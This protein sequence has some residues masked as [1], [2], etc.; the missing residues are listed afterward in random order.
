M[1][2]KVIPITFTK[3]STPPALSHSMSRKMR[4]KSV[5]Q[6]N[7]NGKNSLLISHWNLGSKKWTNKRNQIQALVDT[8]NPDIIFISEANL[9]DLTPPH[10]SLISGYSITLPKTVVRN[11]T[12]RLVLLTKDN[13]EFELMENLM[14]D[15]VSSIWIKISRQG[16][17]G[18]LVCGI[19]REHQY[20]NQQSDWSLQPAE[21]SKRWAQFLRQVETA[22]IS[23]ICHLIGDFNLDYKKWNA[24]D[25]AHLQMITETKD[26]LE[27]GGFFQLIEDVTRTWPGQI[28]SLIDHFWTNEPQKILKVS[29]EVRAVADHN[30]ISASYKDQRERY[31]TSGYQKKVVQKFRPCAVQ[32]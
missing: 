7:G 2:S 19:Y 25:F 5:K 24:P 16:V 17:K 8:N 28:D 3:L 1:D 14:D 20:L 12:A 31:E 26:G 22:R 15:I 32:T 10:E 21:Q 23:S 9:D 13:L 27:A 11:G 30:V 18:L 4:N 6:V 29:N